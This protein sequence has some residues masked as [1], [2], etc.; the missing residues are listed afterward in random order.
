M[1]EQYGIYWADLNPT[2]GCEISKVR[3]CVVI[4]PKEL[5]VCLKTVI[6]IP[7]TTQLRNVPFR[8]KSCLMNTDCEM[9]VDQMRCIDKSRLKGDKIG[10]LSLKETMALRQVLKD[11]FC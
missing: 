9:A 1:V 8:V 2:I 4:S 6:A 7:L 5:N 3:P 10:H 11:M